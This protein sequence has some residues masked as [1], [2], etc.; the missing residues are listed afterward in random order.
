MNIK[1]RVAEWEAEIEVDVQH[2]MCGAT[3]LL[4]RA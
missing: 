3:N 4:F 1:E 2:E